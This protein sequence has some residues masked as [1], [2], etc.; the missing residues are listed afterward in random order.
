[1]TCHWIDEAWTLRST[2]I[3]FRWF[4]TP[5]TGDVAKMHIWEVIQE[6]ELERKKCE[7]TTDGASDTVRE[8]NGMNNLLN[9]ECSSNR[10]I[11]SFHMRYIVHVVSLCVK[12]CHSLM[13]AHVTE[14][15][16][17][18][19]LLRC[20]VKRFDIFEECC[21]ELGVKVTLP[22]LEC[23]TKWSSTFTMLRKSYAL[24]RVM[25]ANVHRIV[26]MQDMV[27]FECEWSTALAMCEFHEFAA[28]L[29]GN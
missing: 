12:E 14:I 17:L 29:T 6:W 28:S 3:D 21:I 2:T 18:L 16:T 9:R 25:N 13:Y 15:R 7:I 27:V 22:S 10:T 24:R 26:G 11:E 5:H 8:M 23:K 20:S 4:P 19:N 1:M